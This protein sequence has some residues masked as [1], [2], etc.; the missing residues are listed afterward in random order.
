MIKMIK[1]LGD[2]LKAD[3]QNSS[4]IILADERP[5]FVYF[6]KRIGDSDDYGFS[7]I[8]SPRG[9]SSAD[10]VDNSPCLVSSSGDGHSREN[11][12]RVVTSDGSAVLRLRLEDVSI[13]DGKPAIDGM[14]SSY[15]AKECVVFK[16]YDAASSVALE[17]Y[18]AVFD[19]SDVIATS[20]RLINRGKEDVK[21]KRLFSLQLDLP[22]G[23][24]EMLTLEGA[25]CRER[26]PKIKTLNGGTYLNASYSGLSSNSSNPFVALTKKGPN[27]FCVE[28][29]LV[30][31]GNHKET[32]ECGNLGG[33]R[34]LS[35][36]NDYLLDYTVKA[37]ESFCAPEAIFTVADD[38]DGASRAMRDF[39]D[40]HII[41]ERMRRRERPIVVNTWETF[42]FDFDEKKLSALC[43]KAAELGIE[44]F[45]LDDGWFGKR[46][47]D[48]S[49]LGDWYE[50]VGK[51]GC[52]LKEFGDKIRAKGLGFGIWVEPEMI[53]ADSDLF[54]T[55]PEFA[56]TID[57]V[58]PMEIR[59][60]L[61]LDTTKREVRDYIV[62]AI[63]CVISKSGADYVKWDCN[64]SVQELK[65]SGSLFHS[66]TLGLYDMLKR[67]TD[68]FPDLIIESCASGGNRFDL[69]MLCFTPQI[70]TS[71]NVDPRYRTAIQEGTLYAY[72]Q[73]SMGTHVGHIPDWHTFNGTSYDNAF[74]VAALGSFGYEFNLTELSDKDTEIVR[75]QIAF[76]KKWRGVLQFGTLTVNERVAERGISCY[77]VA[78]EKCEKAVATV[79]VTQSVFN[80]DYPKIY[81]KGLNADYIYKVGFRQQTEVDGKTT[82]TASGDALA[83]VGVS[84]GDMFSEGAVG[85]N[86]N[87]IQ[88]RMMTFEKI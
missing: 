65:N 27:G 81:I 66:F 44:M 52:S 67:I 76:Y 62:D 25:S 4:L 74:S 45:I 83:C 37:G 61:C 10:D 33:V 19:D 13:L 23:D 50:N 55:H 68:R 57:G 32:V 38:I 2:Y 31:S 48:S 84:L 73:I 53:S 77:T 70:W 86:Y 59:R 9:F 18:F 26:I 46:N 63:S 34:L 64:R 16:Y 8:K 36:I 20:V 40:K 80:R 30:Y 39:V 88:T 79:I 60:Q 6:G 14:P 54:R 12:I 7:G 3:T 87:S 43:D 24:Y 82:F 58:K 49:S 21:I 29:N 56:M 41:S 51:L 35:G 17:Q 47:D 28:S 72:P 42:L 75:E 69:G 78:D 5:K 22:D 71:D 85:K 15:E 1:R 11:M